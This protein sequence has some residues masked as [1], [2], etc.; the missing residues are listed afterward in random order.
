MQSTGYLLYSYVYYR[1][2]NYYPRLN[3]IPVSHPPVPCK[4][5]ALFHC[6]EYGRSSIL[7][8]LKYLTALKSSYKTLQN[9]HHTRH[10]SL[11]IFV[12]FAS[13]W[14]GSMCLG[15]AVVLQ[16]QFRCTL[17]SWAR[18]VVSCT[19]HTT[20]KLDSKVRV[21]SGTTLCR[22][23]YCHWWQRQDPSECRVWLCEESSANVGGAVQHRNEIF[24]MGSKTLMVD[25][26]QLQPLFGE[27]MT[28]ISVLLNT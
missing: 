15:T 26:W 10:H 14:A 24:R 13:N 4:L 16:W 23:R 28:S 7:W 21:T 9:C 6:R 1:H 19:Q 18:S 20:K 5:P 11:C 8:S 2:I 17:T 3:C 22:V 12:V 25:L 27:V